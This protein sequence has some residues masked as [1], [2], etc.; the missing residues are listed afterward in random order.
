MINKLIKSNN[1]KKNIYI[2]ENYNAY[3]IIDYYRKELS[4]I[5][6]WIAKTHLF[7][8][9]MKAKIKIEIKF[10]YALVAS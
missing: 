7:I 8:S 4:N 6:Y 5:S 3:H 10:I 2:E 9:D 1:L